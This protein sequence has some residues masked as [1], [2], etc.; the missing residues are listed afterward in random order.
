MSYSL[1][2]FFDE[3]GNYCGRVE[4]PRGLQDPGSKLKDGD[5]VVF[6]T[7][8]GCLERGLRMRLLVGLVEIYNTPIHFTFPNAYADDFLENLRKWTR[9]SESSEK[10]EAKRIKELGGLK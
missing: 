6:S 4:W 9:A 2:M 8:Q 7:R 3:H 5:I 1:H 10:R